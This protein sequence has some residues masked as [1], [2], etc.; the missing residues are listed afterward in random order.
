MNKQ[1][2]QIIV[3]YLQRRLGQSAG[4]LKLSEKEEL[5]FQIKKSNPFYIGQFMGIDI[6][7]YP[8]KSESYISGDW[9]YPRSE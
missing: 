9:N 5:K 4:F 6:Y 3:C 7:K 1:L 2:I 8:G